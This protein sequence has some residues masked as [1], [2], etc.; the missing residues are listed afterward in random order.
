MKLI[1]AIAS[2]ILSLTTAVATMAQES[3]LFTSDR[4]TDPNV[5]SLCQDKYGYVWIGTRAGLNKFDG[6]RFTHYLHHD[7]STSLPSN[8]ITRIHCDHKQQLWIGTREGLARYDYATDSFRRIL[9]DG[10]TNAPF[11]ESLTADIDG[12]LLIANAGFGLYK[13]HPDSLRAT[14]INH[15]SHND[16]NDYYHR[17]L[18]DSRKR[19]WKLDKSNLIS[20]FDSRSHR[21]LF[22]ARPDMGYIISIVETSPGRVMAVCQY[23]IYLF[24]TDGTQGRLPIQANGI[25]LL[26]CHLKSDGR[27]LLG[28]MASGLYSLDTKTLQLTKINHRLPGTDF[29]TVNVNAILEDRQHNLWIGCDERGLAFIPQRQSPYRRWSFQSQQIVNGSSPSAL[30]QGGDNTLWA[31]VRNNGLYRFDST[32]Q[33]TAQ[34]HTLPNINTIHRDRRGRIWAGTTNALY[35]FDEEKLTFTKVRNID[36]DMVRCIADDGADMLFLSNYGRGLLAIDVST[37]KEFHSNMYDTRN[38]L[39]YL[40][41]DW[42][43]SMY[44]DSKGLLWMATASGVSC[45]NPSTSRFNTFGWNNLLEG[46]L[47]ISLCER[48]DGDILIGTD[49]GLYVF[50][51]KANRAEPCAKELE[52]KNI[53]G[54]VKDQRGRIWCATSG[55]LWKSADGSTAF[56]RQSL[57]RGAMQGGFTENTAVATA[58][59]GI[60]LGTSDGVLTFMPTD[61]KTI[62]QKPRR[63]LLTGI[64]IGGN[65]VNTTTLSNGDVITPSAVEETRHIAVSYLDNTFTLDFSTFNFANAS[66]TGL[67][68]RLNNDKWTTTPTGQSGFTLT[69]LHPGN[70]RLQVRASLEGEYTPVETYTITVRAPWYRSTLAYCLY[71]LAALTLALAVFITAHRRR[72]VRLAEEKMQFLIN[73]THDIRTPLTLILSPLH[74]LMKADHSQADREALQ[75][76]DHNAR[77]ILDLVNQILDIRKIDKRQMKLQCQ[78][79]QLVPFVNGIYKVFAPHAKE[80]GIDFRFV[81]PQGVEAWID[82]K[83]FDKVLQNLLSNAFK[84][85]DDGGSV[86]I[87][88]AADESHLSISVADT[89]SGLR[90]AEIPYLFKRFYQSASNNISGKDGTGIG[91]NLCMKIVEMHHGT[92][93]AQNRTD[94]TTGSLFTVTIP[95]GNSHLKPEEML[96]VVA[97]E[98]ESQPTAKKSSLRSRVLLV[99]DDAEITDYIVG[100]LSHRFRFGVCHNGKAAIHELLTATDRYDLVISDIMMPEIDGFTLLRLIKTNA[101]TSH[102]PVMLLTTEAA[103]GNRLKG[104]SEGADAFL[105]KPFIVEELELKAASILANIQRQRGEYSGNKRQAGRVVA[106]DIRDNDQELMD[107][108]MKSINKNIGDS[109][110]T[111]EQLAAEVG[112]SR[113]HLHR[114]I[115]ELTGITTSEFIRNIR[116]EQ[117][118]RLLKERKIN[119]SQVAYSMGY[120]NVSHFA[121]IFKQHFGVSPTEYVG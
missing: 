105:A 35:R 10:P 93:T 37:G 48:N 119:I 39:G 99:D 51:R 7:D 40:C 104:L 4:L 21:F 12:H 78:A 114:R 61:E 15:F 11:I 13:L 25:E 50:N 20:C 19:L 33:I 77:R 73:A 9:F 111:V 107:R 79:T 91:L 17:L 115:K 82:R 31:V 94:G 2:I 30:C 75:T 81:H 106:T 80:R 108:I 6:H 121:R 55:E 117:S 43:F 46:R 69:H 72:T 88:L 41:N 68:Y 18:I 70:Y 90:E 56:V 59:G 22:S 84:F 103:I 65:H 49:A 110:F 96:S 66:E 98:G 26:S 67:E 3:R 71:C 28:T 120:S 63:L 64:S 27:L 44:H 101:Q 92:I 85:T 112:L 52:G 60:A 32:G 97:Q 89:G 24:D 83:L 118:A 36:G 53:L 74:K 47:C 5:R 29:A 34:L 116:M 54:I 86:S 57:G 16:Y 42:I 100:E 38:P 23:G 95:L 102:I 45:L 87:G 1:K 76:I 113:V 62:R 14:R 109:D 8:F 58:V